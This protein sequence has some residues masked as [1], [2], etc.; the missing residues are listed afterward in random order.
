MPNT[1]LPDGQADNRLV[2]QRGH[3]AVTTLG[4][5]EYI[6]QAH[7]FE[8][9]A[10][11]LAEGAPAQEV[12]RSAREEA[13]ATTK[14][15]LAIDFLL[16]ELRHAGLMTQGMARL[17]HYF[18]AFQTFVVGEG[19]SERGRFDLRRGFLLLSQEAKYR[20]GPLGGGVL[21]TR[22]GLFLY[23]FEVLCR[24]RLGY[25]RGLT[26][27][28]ADPAYDEAWRTWILAIRRQ[29]GMVDLADLIYVN[30]ALAQQRASG[31]AEG[32]EALFGVSEGRIALANRRKDPLYL[33]NSL[34][35]HLGYPAPPRPEVGQ[36]KEDLIPQLAR[37]IEHLEKRLKLIEEEQR[38]GFDLS[39]FY[40]DPQTKGL[41][42]SGEGPPA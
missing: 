34:H 3:A 15:P 38:G 26:A 18:T 39:K 41:A 32:T 13:L 25:D 36:E 7:F 10:T 14:L 29:V 1:S 16:D 37:R 5:D 20:A 19:E 9:L 6:E 30:S 28:S 23:Q 12:L 33:F 42:E 35:R 2:D 31:V 21:P 22:Q 40:V 11:R 17:A 24:N 27:I 4:S 8:M